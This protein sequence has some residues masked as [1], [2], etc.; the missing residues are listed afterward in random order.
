V[1]SDDFRREV[2][3]AVGQLPERDRMIVE[4]YYFR[5]IGFKEIGQIL[6]V[7]ESRVS[8]LHTRIMARLKP[9]LEGVEVAA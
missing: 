1:E 6:G 9:L 3:R 5:E 4:L 8:Q 7:T 2:R